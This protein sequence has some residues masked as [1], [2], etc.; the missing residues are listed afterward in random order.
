MAAWATAW[1]VVGVGKGNISSVSNAITA[2]WET[3]WGGVGVGKGN[4]GSV[5]KTSGVGPF[6]AAAACGGVGMVN[7]RVCVFRLRPA[8]ARARS[9]PPKM[10]A[11]APYQRRGEAS[12]RTTLA[13]LFVRL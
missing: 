1:C 5:R 11:W 3:A 9:G 13:F 6:P 12:A 4:I 8:E 2:A 10:A 7:L